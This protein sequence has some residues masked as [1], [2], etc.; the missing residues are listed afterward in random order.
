MF[1]EYHTYKKLTAKNSY[2]DSKHPKRAYNEKKQKV[3]E[4]GDAL[5]EPFYYDEILHVSAK[6]YSKMKDIIANLMLKKMRNFELN[7]IALIP[8]EYKIIMRAFEKDLDKTVTAYDL[9]QSVGKSAKQIERYLSDLQAEFS[10]IINIKKGRK[11]A[12]KL[13]DSFEVFIEIFK[14]E[15]DFS[16][17]FYLAEQSSPELFEKLEYTMSN[18]HDT[19]L[20][21]NSIFEKLTN[22]SVFNRLKEAVVKREYRKIKLDN[23]LAFQE[24]KPIKLAFVDNN[25]YLAYVDEK[26]VLK[27]GRV[28]FIEEVTYASKNY[29]QKSSVKKH[30]KI[31]N[32]NLQN[33]MTL[34]DKEPRKVTIRAMSSVAKYFSEGM[35][36]FLPSQTFIR[37]EDDG[38]VIFT[39]SY[40]QELEVFPLIQKWMPNLVIVEPAELQE[41]YVKKLQQAIRNNSN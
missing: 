18:R 4:I 25:W 38:S 11:N 23:D 29:F 15:E 3:E 41:S 39:L 40:T 26:D 12:Y 28:A 35:K 34:F 32:E 7:E 9:E 17:L 5:S 16:E 13:V 2:P 22:R 33:A 6:E 10:N 14:R 37:K 21:R 27:L 31:L 36:T 8:R 19:Y 1:D 30:L 24:V 20:F